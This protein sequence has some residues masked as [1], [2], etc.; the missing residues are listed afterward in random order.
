MLI[1]E[2]NLMNLINPS[3]AIVMLQYHPLII[4]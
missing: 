3:F 2:T 1:R 4:D